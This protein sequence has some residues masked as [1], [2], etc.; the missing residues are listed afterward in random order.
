MIK[1]HSNLL[2]ILP[3]NLLFSKGLQRKLEHRHLIGM[4]LFV[5]QRVER[6]ASLVFFYV[7]IGISY[8]VP[9]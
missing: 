4:S 6:I 8:L 5:L 2:N 3:I 1:Y 7:V 9:E